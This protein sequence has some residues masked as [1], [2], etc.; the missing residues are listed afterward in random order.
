M[1]YTIN[2]TNNYKNIILKNENEEFSIELNKQIKVFH[3]DIVK[4]DKNTKDLSI[5]KSN[6][7]YK[8]I[9]GILQINKKMIYG[10]NNKKNPYYLFKPLDNHYPNFYVAINDKNLKNKNGSYYIT[11]KYNLWDKKL[12]YGIM[13]K[14]I[15][16]IGVKENEI[17]KLIHFY[18][19]DTRN[20]KI[21]NI[22]HNNT[23][24]DIFDE[25][26]LKNVKKRTDLKVISIDPKN[27]K[28]IDDALSI[29]YI[30]NI[31]RIGIHI[32]DVSSWYFKLNLDKF[33]R[34]NRYF[35]VYLKNNK[36]N[37][38][39]NVLSDN[40]MSLI[41]R[42][43]RLSLSLYIDF[44]ENDEIIKYYYENN[45]IN[46][47]KNYSY[48]KF[49]NI[50]NSND[51]KYK[52]YYD[53]FELSKK[54]GFSKEEEYD[55]HNMIENYMILANK[56]TGEY[57][58]KN[59]KNPILRY[60][61][62]TKYNIDFEKIDN[63]ELRHF[64]KIFQTKSASYKEY[65]G[66]D[67]NYY[68]FGLNLNLYAHFTSPIRRF[69]DILNHIKIKS[70]LF[71]TDY[72]IKNNDIDDINQTN[73]NLRKMDR[74]MNE[75]EKIESLRDKTVK[76][77]LVN[78]KDNY[79]YFYISEYNLYMKKRIFYNDDMMKDIK[80]IHNE[81]NF[82]VIN[83]KNKKGIKLKKFFSYDIS[84]KKLLNTNLFYYQIIKY[85]FQKMV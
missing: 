85:D 45:I 55:S 58:V 33:I 27:S 48:E 57:L 40:L 22:K 62:E 13:D 5:I 59:N 10:L 49:N 68:H 52:E 67:F 72:S 20:M 17:Q 64:L 37:L 46:V 35:T 80:F 78:Y 66:E 24:Y 4:Y 82:E 70:C 14:F 51:K 42:Q 30:D 34:K 60:H 28:D 25:N 29:E 18:N 38:F 1:E 74:E 6:I 43:D 44:N 84:I 79:L 54:L 69:I 81:D 8:R 41:Q 21:K 77:Y 83:I 7:K 71:N 75:I 53:L 12:P 16:E 9:V 11:I 63:K 56:I 3:E 26:D 65:D 31:K 76:G 50:L 2:I 23:I 73:K 61:E 32:A 15:G 36:Y 19:I 47:N 39:P